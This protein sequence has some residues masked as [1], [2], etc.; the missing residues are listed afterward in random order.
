MA[1]SASTG[2]VGFSPV[3]AGTTSYDVRAG[4]IRPLV[5][6]VMTSSI[7]SIGVSVA[8]A[9]LAIGL[10]ACSQTTYGTGTTPGMQTIQ[11]LAGIADLGGQAK[12]PIKYQARP[13]LVAPPPGTPLPPPGS[14][15]KEVAGNWPNDPDAQAKQMKEQAAAREK[16]CADQ[17]NQTK[18]ECRDPGFRIVPSQTASASREPSPTLLHMNMKHGQQADSTPEQNAQAMKLFAEAKGQ[19]AVDENGKPI[20]RYLTDPPGDYRV[21]DPSAPVTFDNKPK[22]KKWHWPWEKDTTNASDALTP[23]TSGSGAAGTPSTTTSPPG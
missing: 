1:V 23:D 21:P 12:D 22:Q 8:A 14:E 7:R 6:G 9:A 15:P 20:R 4:A 2:S 18:P 3:F 11:D 13:G 5:T 10:G 17:M 19:V 16:F